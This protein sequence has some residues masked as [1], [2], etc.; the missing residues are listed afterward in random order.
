MGTVMRYLFVGML[1]MAIAVA[2][3]GC[4]EGNSEPGKEENGKEKEARMSVTVTWLGHASF[5]ISDGTN[6]IYIDPWKLKDE[7]HDATLV[8]VSH[9]HGDHY[10]ADDIAKVSK[11]GT[12]LIAAGDV[13][14]KHGE[15]KAIA[16]GDEIELEGVT[17]EAVPAYNPEKRFHPKDNKWVGFVVTVGSKRIYYAGDTDITDEMKALKDIDLALLPV[18]G[19]YTMTADEAATAAKAF[20]PKMAVPYHYGDIIGKKSDAEHF[21]EKAGC[22]VKILDPGDSLEL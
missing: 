11:D 4:G 17:I 7:P 9:S 18:G 3:C 19:K 15:G 21:A 13:V 6:A 5:R 12:T 22:E 10:S 20:K 8:L 16:P 1:G 14:E 2:V